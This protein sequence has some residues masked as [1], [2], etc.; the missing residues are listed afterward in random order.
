MAELL[1]QARQLLDAGLRGL[2]IDSGVPPG[3]VSPAALELDP[4]WALLA[5]RDVPVLLHLGGDLGFLG[6]SQWSQAE[7]FAHNKTAL[8]VGSDPYSYATVHLSA[9]HWL[10]VMVMGGV[11]ERHPR[12]RFGAIELGGHWLAPLAENLDMWA[13]TIFEKRIRSTLSAKPSEYLARNVRVTPHNILEPIAD[14]MSRNPAL[15]DCYCFSTDYPHLEGGTRIKSRCYEALAPLGEEVLE[16]YFSANAEWLLPGEEAD[17][18]DWPP[19]GGG[20]TDASR[21]PR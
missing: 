16:K 12:L 18:R 2:L 17:S 9:E 7:A 3:G 6:A 13:T 8:E 15:S 20:L 4:F 19:S 21:A 5:E 1:N 10:T 11:F 14:F